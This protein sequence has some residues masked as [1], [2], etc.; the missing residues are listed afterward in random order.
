[1]LEAIK[2]IKSTPKN[3]R[4]FGLILGGILL[5]LALAGWWKGK[6]TYPYWLV[7]GL[8]FFAAGALKPSLLKQI[9]TAWMCVAVM[10]GWVVT[11]VL[12]IALFYLVLT[13]LGLM[14]RLAGKNILSPKLPDSPTYWIPRATKKKTI[15]YENQF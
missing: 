6:T 2:N 8:V 3:L 4:S 11:H 14:N 12:L 10:I 1:M 7:G 9:Y 13:P 15:D 5:A